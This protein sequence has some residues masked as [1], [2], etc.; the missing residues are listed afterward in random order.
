MK[1]FHCRLIKGD[2]FKLA[3]RISLVVTPFSEKGKEREIAD[4]RW[5]VVDGRWC[6]RGRWLEG[7]G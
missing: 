4:G 1:A 2:I 3:S 7:R 5:E 6:V